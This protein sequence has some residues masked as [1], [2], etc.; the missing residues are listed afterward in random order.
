MRRPMRHAEFLAR[1][2]S[3]GT[4]I[5]RNWTV[6]EVIDFV[7]AHLG[8]GDGRSGLGEGARHCFGRPLETLTI[9]EVAL[10]LAVA[11]SAKGYDPV[12]RPDSALRGRSD[13]LERMRSG[14]LIDDDALRRATAVPIRVLPSC[15]ATRPGAS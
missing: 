15:A 9:D 11:R 13:V 4:W 8:M 14:G 10:L 5:S 2:L 12:C 3:R 7:G 1:S 6:E